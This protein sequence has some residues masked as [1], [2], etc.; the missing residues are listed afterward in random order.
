MDPDDLQR[1]IAE[2]RDAKA[3]KVVAWLEHANGPDRRCRRC[4]LPVHRDQDRRWVHDLTFGG[5]SA[6]CQAPGFKR[7]AVKVPHS[8]ETWTVARVAGA[9]PAERDRISELAGLVKPCSDRTWER[10]VVLF[11]ARV[12]PGGSTP[13]EG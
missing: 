4:W 8:V 10:V 3:S 12:A 9:S 11:R 1:M 6:D 13:S 7:L 2:K 5:T